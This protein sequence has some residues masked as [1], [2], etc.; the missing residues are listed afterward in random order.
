MGFERI[1]KYVLLVSG[2]G[3]I[4]GSAGIVFLMFL[5]CADI[6]GRYVLKSPILGAFE[7]S[8]FIMAG[9]IFIGFAYTQAQKAH[10]K[11]DLLIT[12]LPND[13]QYF[14]QIFNLSVILAFYALIVWR[15]GA[16]VW[17]A[18]VLD[19]KTTGLAR[20]PYWPARA[21]VPLGGGLFCLQIII[22]I[23]DEIKGRRSKQYGS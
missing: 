10:I 18:F 1:K 8:E 23:V 22:D 2:G 13:T 17:E 6:I 19:D 7:L 3:N 21:V 4:L 12:H 16:G 5:I 9:I 20:I 15:G 11:I 14:L